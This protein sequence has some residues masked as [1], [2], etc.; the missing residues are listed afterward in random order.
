[1]VS[2]ATLSKDDHGDAAPALDEISVVEK[3]VA[4][5]PG[6]RRE[7]LR[8]TGLGLLLLSFQTLGMVTFFF[9]LLRGIYLR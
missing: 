8:V 5:D 3:R 2:S 9:D 6:M 7:A 4:V 1:M